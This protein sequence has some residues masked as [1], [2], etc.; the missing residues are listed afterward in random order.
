MRI[1]PWALRDPSAAAAIEGAAIAAKGF[2]QSCIFLPLGRKEVGRW[3]SIAALPLETQ[4]P[5]S[6]SSL[7]HT[8]DKNKIKKIKEFEEDDAA[9][10]TPL[11]VFALKARMKD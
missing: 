2:S 5:S 7:L 4:P 3:N 11:R 8:R 1:A 10:K 9:L 6:P